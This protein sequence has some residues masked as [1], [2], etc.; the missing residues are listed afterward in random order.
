[1]LC[2]LDWE[3]AETKNPLPTDV[4]SSKSRIPC[5]AGLPGSTQRVPRSDQLVPGSGHP[6]LVP[7][8]PW[9]G[10][11]HVS[12]VGALFTSSEAFT[13]KKTDFPT[14]KPD[15]PAINMSAADGGI[16]LA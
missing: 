9:S 10:S 5:Q 2:L 14:K 16:E 11:R 15:F 3:V 7:D 13:Q 12:P 6:S 8:R 4:G 1:M